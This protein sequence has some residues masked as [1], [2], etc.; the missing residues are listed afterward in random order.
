MESVLQGIPGV[1]AYLD[2]ILVAAVMDE[3]PLRRLEMVFERLEK[4]GLQVNVH[5]LG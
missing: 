1:I 5:P 4:A 3:E 2:D